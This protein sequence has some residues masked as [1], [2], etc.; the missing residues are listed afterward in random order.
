MKIEEMSNDQILALWS[1]TCEARSKGSW[2]TEHIDTA[3]I[4]KCTRILGERGY[5]TA[6]AAEEA[7]KIAPK[8]G[9]D[10]HLIEVD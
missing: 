6:K 9:A 10:G 8:R 3:I 7:K 1:E 5:F 4:E 2:M